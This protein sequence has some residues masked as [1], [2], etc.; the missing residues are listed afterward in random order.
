[1]K[2][3]TTVFAACLLITGCADLTPAQKHWAEAGAA[4]LAVG[5]IAA[6]K[7]D[8]GGNSTAASGGELTKPGVPCHM[9]PDGTCR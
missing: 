9:Q 8:H 4:V 6:Y 7:A 2:A 3:L 5:A 1:M